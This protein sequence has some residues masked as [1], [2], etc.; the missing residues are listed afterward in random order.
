MNKIE[1]FVSL[2]HKK[3]LREEVLTISNK[4][5]DLLK[6]SQHIRK[7]QAEKLKEMELVKEKIKEIAKLT[8][9]F[10]KVMPHI[11]IANIDEEAEDIRYSEQLDALERSIQKI[12]KKLQS[13]E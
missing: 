1:Y 10:R 7:L 2:E 5:I 12:E 3:E 4:M 6:F 11:K 9:E 8:V 13:L